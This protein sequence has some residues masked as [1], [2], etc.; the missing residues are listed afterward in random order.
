MIW[1]NLIIGVVRHIVSCVLC[2][3]CCHRL[4]CFVLE[5]CFGMRSIV[6]NWHHFPTRIVILCITIINYLSLS[7]LCYFLERRSNSLAL[8]RRANYSSILAVVTAVN[9]VVR[10]RVWLDHS[11]VG[12]LRLMAVCHIGYTYWCL[13]KNIAIDVWY[14]IKFCQIIVAIIVQYKLLRLLNFIIVCI[15]LIAIIC[16]IKLMR[17]VWFGYWLT[18][19]SLS[20]LLFRAR[21]RTLPRRTWWISEF[22]NVFL[23]FD[24]CHRRSIAT[25]HSA[26]IVLGWIVIILIITIAIRIAIVIILI[27][28][29]DS[30]GDDIVVSLIAVLTESRCSARLIRQTILFHIIAGWTSL[31][32]HAIHHH[33]RQNDIFHHAPAIC[34]LDCPQPQNEVDAVFKI[35]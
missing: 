35:D 12:K 18:F 10:I 17:Q 21:S 31:A 7:L 34:L 27:S 25:L 23:A 11:R 1:H 30:V 2:C 3:V 16:I 24:W 22:F 15:L 4:V 19:R 26:I 20:W 32:I 8:V 28:I 33:R 5:V 13:L 29:V 6:D 9:G 14:S